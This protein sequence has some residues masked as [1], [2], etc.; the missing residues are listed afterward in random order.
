MY[1]ASP[2][3]RIRKEGEN[4]VD[5]HYGCQVGKLRNGSGTQETKTE[6]LSE[7]LWNFKQVFLSMRLIQT[8]HFRVQCTFLLRKINC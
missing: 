5:V 2:E 4:G 6:E 3:V 7:N 8:S 1:F